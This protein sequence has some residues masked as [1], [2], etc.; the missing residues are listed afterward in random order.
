MD[1]LSLASISLFDIARF[2][3]T[4]TARS[5]IASRY[6]EARRDTL[7][8]HFVDDIDSLKSLMDDTGAVISGSLALRLFLP[9]DAVQWPINDMDLYV[10]NSS[11]ADV[12][13]HFIRQGYQLSNQSPSSAPYAYGD[14]TQIE[15]VITMINSGKKV[16]IIISKSSSSILPIF[17]F[18]STIVMNYFNSNT[19][20]A[21]YPELTKR[22]RGLINGIRFASGS[23]SDR[24]LSCL[25][26]YT[27]RGF[28]FARDLNSWETEDAADSHQCGEH[29]D[30]PQRLRT[31]VD[32]GCFTVKIGSSEDQ[33]HE[34]TRPVAWCLGGSPCNI[35]TVELPS[36]VFAV[37]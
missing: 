22:K 11:C 19:F 37:T 24:S 36:L 27:A 3:D 30:C 18:H 17:F 10:P 7:L 20:F 33:R 14:M 25:L 23:L 29:F 12:V 32:R 13:T 9:E 4:Y 28:K 1:P 2:R 8:T 31:S 16:D 5:S 15:T 6:I 21:A 34:A 35:D 26:K